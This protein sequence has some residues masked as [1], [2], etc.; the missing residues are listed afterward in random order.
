[1]PTLPGGN[2]FS[3]G[4]TCD[5]AVPVCAHGPL[6]STR[7]K[8]T[9]NGINLIDLDNSE[10]DPFY[11]E[12]DNRPAPPGFTTGAGFERAIEIR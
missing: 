5:E 4:G 12:K 2:F 7:S 6:G 9:L 3:G 1:M 10:I 11:I 8:I